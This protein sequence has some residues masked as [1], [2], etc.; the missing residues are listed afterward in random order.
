MNLILRTFVALVILLPVARYVSAVDRDRQYTA[1]ADQVSAAFPGPQP[2]GN[3][4][5]AFSPVRSSLPAVKILDVRATRSPVLI[6]PNES[7]FDTIG[8]APTHGVLETPF[9]TP[10][11]TGGDSAAKEKKPDLSYGYNKG[12][13]IA[14]KYPAKNC[15]PE[16]AFRFQFNTLFQM[17]HT[18]FNSDGPNPDQNFFEFER[19]FLIF[20]G[21]VYSEDLTYHIKL[22]GDSDGRQTVDLLDC[23]FT[24]DLGHHDLGWNKG[25]FGLKFGQWKIPYSRSRAEAAQRMQFSERAMA[26]DFFDL[27]RALGFAIYGGGDWLDQKYGWEVGIFNGFA[28]QG[29]RPSELDTNFAY[30]GRVFYDLFGEYGNDGEPDYSWH[31][32]PAVRVGGG[33]GFSTLTP[34]EGLREASRIG[35]IDSGATLVSLLPPGADEFNALLVALDANFKYRGFSFIGEFYYREISGIAAGVPRLTDHGMM[36]QAGYFVI[37]EKL[38]LVSRWSRLAGDSGSLGV[39]RRSAEEI[40]GGIGWYIDGQSRKFVIDV[41]RLNGAPINSTRLNIRP[42][43]QGWLVRSQFQLFF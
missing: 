28:T 23:Y 11:G 24:Y 36:L 18:Y 5:A 33:F 10:T 21:H 17:R 12:F 16:T 32:S 1:S 9:A 25:H 19:A 7:V 22:D 35:T 39:V 42:G 31:E 2:G 14:A 40:S 8:Y 34:S 30:A 6:D 38:E 37:P 43:D 4:P 20:R 13:F 26:S 29:F 15:E 3:Y 41:T 27:N